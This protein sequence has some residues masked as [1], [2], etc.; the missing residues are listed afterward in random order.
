MTRSVPPA[1]RPL[2]P[3]EAQQAL[4]AWGVLYRSQLRQPAA[5]RADPRPLKDLTVEELFAVPGGN[6]SETIK[7]MAAEPGYLWLQRKPDGE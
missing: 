4:D 6:P 3:G 5:T 1:K 2:A 7:E